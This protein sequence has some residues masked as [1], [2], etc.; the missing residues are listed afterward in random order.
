MGLRT[1]WGTAGKMYVCSYYCFISTHQFHFILLFLSI[2][3]IPTYYSLYTFIILELVTDHF[4]LQNRTVNV[5]RVV[6][7][8]HNLE[9]KGT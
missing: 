2:L 9:T 3:S 6:N 7:V 1:D 4:E 5:E 8:F